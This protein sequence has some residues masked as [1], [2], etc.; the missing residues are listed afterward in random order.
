M[1]EK[2]FKIMSKK[3]ITIQDNYSL[4]S[5]Y[6]MMQTH[7]IR[8]LPVLNSDN[9]V[10]GIISDRDLMR[11]MSSTVK[12]NNNVRFEDLSFPKN[13]VVSDYMTWPVS[14]VQ[15]SS[16][17]H[18]TVQMML[19]NKI[20]SVL[21]VTKTDDVVGIVTTDDCLYY[22]LKLLK[23]QDSKIVATVE[24][25]FLNPMVGAY[26]NALSQSGI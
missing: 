25:L 23:D 19:Q 3:L 12:A 15:E 21:V 17:L 16:L 13:S 5:A 26:A 6:N 4:E 8:H 9:E 18:D 24:S 20:S 1:S 11:G 7:N 14:V 10:V 2:T 22:L